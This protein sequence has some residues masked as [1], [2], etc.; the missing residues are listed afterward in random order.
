MPRSG[1][2]LRVG[3]LILMVLAARV[4]PAQARAASPARE[5]QGT[6][7]DSAARATA[8]RVARDIMRVARYCALVT[9]DASAGPVARTIDPAPP[10]SLMVVRFVT[11]PRTRKVRQLAAD[12]RV[13]LY[14]FDATAQRYATL[15]GRARVVT[16]ADDRARRW[17]EA[18]TPFYPDRERSATLYE[19][20]PERLEVVSPGEGLLGDSLSWAPPTVRFPP[21]RRSR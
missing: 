13:A 9:R 2:A 11:N 15:Y 12:P 4:L 16:N 3:T 19:V 10:D 7:L 21:A 20:I 1:S 5:L 18:W 14:Y 6:P 17:H 8:L